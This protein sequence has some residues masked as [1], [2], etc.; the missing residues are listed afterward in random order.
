M[1]Y[2]NRTLIILLTIAVMAVS[3]LFCLHILQVISLEKFVLLSLVAE[4]IRPLVEGGLKTRIMSGG[5]SLCVF[6]LGAVLLY[7]ELHPIFSR[8]PQFL[9]LK[10]DLGRIEI[11]KTCVGKFID[12]EVKNLN[13]VI[14]TTS[15]IK[16]KKDGIHI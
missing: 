3:L 15:K 9:I 2:L 4:Q 7:F 11:A 8:E 6:F 5:I 12:Y 16:D 13:G 1:N 10:D 14:E